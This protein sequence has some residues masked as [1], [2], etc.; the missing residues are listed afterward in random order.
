MSSYKSRND[1]DWLASEQKKGSWFTTGIGILVVIAVLLLILWFI[2]SATNNRKYVNVNVQ[3]A[4]NVNKSGKPSNYQWLNPV[5]QRY[6]YNGC[7]N[8]NGRPI[9]VVLPIEAGSQPANANDCYNQ[10][11]RITGGTATKFGLISG[12]DGNVHCFFNDGQSVHL[13]QNLGIAGASFCQGD[14]QGDPIGSAG[15][16]AL[17]TINKGLV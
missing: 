11:N 12:A 8:T 7:F 13:P 2:I 17:F 6:S 10:A 4:N 3:P 5:S 1:M 9:Q 16:I 15:N 14:L